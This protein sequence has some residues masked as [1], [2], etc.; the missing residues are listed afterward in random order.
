MR[1]GAFRWLPRG[2]RGSNVIETRAHR[3]ATDMGRKY[4][5]GQS[6]HL[7]TGP[8]TASKLQELI[9]IRLYIHMILT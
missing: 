8:N 1:D 9:F 3:P 2:S 5:G 7:D 6:M 4:T